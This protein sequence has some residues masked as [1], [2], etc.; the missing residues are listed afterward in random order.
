MK[1]KELFVIRPSDDMEEIYEKFVLYLQN[2]G[3]KIVK[4]VKNEKK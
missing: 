3:I 1:K 2:Q 4:G